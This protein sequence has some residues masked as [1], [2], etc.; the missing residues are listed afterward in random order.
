MSIL[1]V[2]SAVLDHVFRCATLPLPGETVLGV[3]EGTYAG[4][5]GANQAVAASRLGAEVSFVG[6]V[7][8]DAAGRELTASLV[9]AGVNVESLEVSMGLPSGAAL[10]TLDG[11]G[12]NSIVVV[13]GANSEVIPEIIPSSVLGCDVL[14]VGLEIPMSTVSWCLRHFSGVKILNPAPAHQLNESFLGD[15]DI[16]VPNE[17]ETFHLTGISPQDENSCNE[18]ATSLLAYGMKH[19]ILTLGE[20]GAYWG[21]SAGKRQHFPARAVTPIDTTGAGDSFCGALAVGIDLGYSMEAAVGFANECAAYSI[22]RK[23]AQ[24]SFPVLAEVQE[25]AASH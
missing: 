16:L 11:A 12:Q 13:P 1:V 2:G 9:S 15:V 18:A 3:A 5:K 14:L 7:G 8:N 19:V 4:G 20:R 22:L 17:S 10:I 25:I 24:T 21:S 23:G 6:V